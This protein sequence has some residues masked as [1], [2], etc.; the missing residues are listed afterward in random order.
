MEEYGDN[1]V[2]RKQMRALDGKQEIYLGPA[3]KLGSAY[4]RQTKPHIK[5]TCKQYVSLWLQ[6]SEESEAPKEYLPFLG[7]MLT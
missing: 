3:R 2:D 4:L 6:Y 7:L 5:L 1:G